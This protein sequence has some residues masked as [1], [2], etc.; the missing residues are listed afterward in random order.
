MLAAAAAAAAEPLARVSR[1]GGASVACSWDDVVSAE[2]KG[3]ANDGEADGEARA[4]AVSKARRPCCWY[5]DTP[6]AAARESSSFNCCLGA[7]LSTAGGGP[8]AAEAPAFSSSSKCASLRGPS[9][10]FSF[11]SP[12]SGRFILSRQERQPKNLCAF[13][14]TSFV[15]SHTV[16][17]NNTRSRL[18]T[19]IIMWS[20]WLLMTSQ[21]VNHALMICIGIHPSSPEVQRWF[22]YCSMG[23]ANALTTAPQLIAVCII[24]RACFAFSSTAASAAA[25]SCNGSPPFFKHGDNLS[26]MAR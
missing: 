11:I 2:G 8:A 12:W 5:C 25:A 7:P 23:R 16:V 3:A 22:K 18:N 20:T 4:G 17:S 1:C 13:P 24:T 9:S 19:R 21:S 10:S 6:T 15:G 14:R 26:M